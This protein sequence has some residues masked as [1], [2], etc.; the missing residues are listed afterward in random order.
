MQLRS[1]IPEKS[2]KVGLRKSDIHGKVA[3]TAESEEEDA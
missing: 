2:I 3:E 1:K